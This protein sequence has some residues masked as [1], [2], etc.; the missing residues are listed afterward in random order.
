MCLYEIL[1]VYTRF[2][3]LY[4]VRQVEKQQLDNRSVK[5]IFLPTQTGENILTQN[6]HMKISNN[7]LFPN[8]GIII[9][10]LE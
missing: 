6:F 9:S 10:L 7:E 2:G 8:Y 1:N 3:K 5:K 4:L